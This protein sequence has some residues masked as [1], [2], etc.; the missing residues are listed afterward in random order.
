MATPKKKFE[1]VDDY[2]ASFPADVQKI[3]RLVQKTIQKAVPDA[4]ELI[5]YQIPAFKRNG[6]W[7][8]YYSTYTNHY[9]L[10]CPPPFTVFEKYKDELSAF[11]VSKSAIKFPYEK[12]VPV[13]LIA[14]MAKFRKGAKT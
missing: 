5:S 8:F 11:E 4:E 9:S 2:I 14:E 1:N 3:L 7:I 10:S 13:K 6:V 12:P